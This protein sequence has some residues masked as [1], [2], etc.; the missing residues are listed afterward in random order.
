MMI[1]G[2]KRIKAIG[3]SPDFVFRVMRATAKLRAASGLGQAG[4][5]REIPD[6]HEKWG[7]LPSDQC[8]VLK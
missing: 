2:V 5:I 6:F 3:V 8:E 1:K 4:I 7:K